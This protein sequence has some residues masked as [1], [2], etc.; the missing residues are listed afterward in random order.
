MKT[1]FLSIAVAASLA[2]STLNAA[3]DSEI[4]ALKAQIAELEK[5]TDLLLEETADIKSGSF[6]YTEVDT[7]KTLSG[8]GDAASKV[9]YSKSPLSIGGYGEMYY[10]NPDNGDAIADVYR[11]V[12]YFGYK[13]SDTIILNTELEFE[14]GDEMTVEFMYLDFLI[15]NAFNVRLGHLLVPMGLVNIRHEPTLFNTVQRPDVEK[16]LLPSTWHETGVLAYGKI[17]DTGLNYTAGFVNALNLNNDGTDTGWIRSGRMGGHKATMNRV[18]GVARLDYTGVN[19]LL[20]GAS[21]YYGD[22]AQGDPSGSTAFIYDVHATY[23]NSGFKFRGLY[24]A[25]SVDDAQTWNE[26]AAATEASGYYVNTEYDILAA[27]GGS[28]TRLPLFVQYENY[29]TTESI[30]TGTAPNNETAVTTVGVNYF[31]HDQVVLKL[32]YAMK[33]YDDTAQTDVDTVSF[34]LGFVF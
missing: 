20:V 7:A 23:E 14:H 21:A 8:M 17:G 18:A 3:S 29:N 34:G 22:A 11:F 1:R 27:V 24:T 6:S 2:A 25:T 5:K 13:F 31:P 10:A 15:D 4:E 9:Y 19:G 30:V 16:Q 26:A 33:D 32:D 12:P 28:E